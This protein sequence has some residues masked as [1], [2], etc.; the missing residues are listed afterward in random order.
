MID[1]D[2]YVYI[3]DRIKDMINRGGE[4]VYSV[5]VEKAIRCHPSVD[6]VAVV[7]VADPVFGE[8][9]KAFIILKPA[10][11]ATIKEIQ[12]HCRSILADYKVP[13]YVEFVNIFPRNPT[14]KIL[15]SE[16]RRK[17]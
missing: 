6:D 10:T 14:G 9:V 4:N 12:D 13:K 17:Q 2:G 11:V 1:Q 3:L 8:E 5:E 15:K 16:L 7:G